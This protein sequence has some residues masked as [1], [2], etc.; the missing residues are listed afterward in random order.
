MFQ[1]KWWDNDLCQNHH[2]MQIVGLIK[3][4]SSDLSPK[5]C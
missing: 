5:A 4:T 3:A 2:G 1:I